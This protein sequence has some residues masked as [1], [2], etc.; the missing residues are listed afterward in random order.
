[1][2]FWCLFCIFMTFYPILNPPL[3]CECL[4]TYT[5]RTCKLA[6]P[7]D[8]AL[9]IH[10]AYAQTNKQ[11]DHRNKRLC[12][13]RVNPIQHSPYTNRFDNQLFLL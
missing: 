5:E 3:T 9:S 2:C 4:Y 1:M 7:C 13:Y 11:H 6:I 10:L 8:P 12:P